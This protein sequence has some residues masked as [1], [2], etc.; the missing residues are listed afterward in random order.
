MVTLYANLCFL[1]HV[2]E[3]KKKTGRGP[4]QMTRFWEDHDI[5]NKVNLKFNR[6]GQP[7]G[8]KTCK[9]TNVIGY[10]VKGKTISLGYP[11]WSKVPK[12]S[13]ENLWASIKVYST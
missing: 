5:N 7:C 2:L 1:M 4:T 8:F 10:F 11:N 13:K 9:L 3:P 6:F 12:A